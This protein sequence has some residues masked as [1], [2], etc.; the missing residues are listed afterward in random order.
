MSKDLELANRICQELQHR[1]GHAALELMQLYGRCLEAFTRKRVGKINLPEM[2]SDQWV[3]DLLQGFWKKK[4]LE[5]KV[6]CAYQGRKGASLK[7]FLFSVMRNY[8]SQQFKEIIR[9]REI[10]IDDLTENWEPSP[11]SEENEDT[12]IKKIDTAEVPDDDVQE[13]LQR[14]YVDMAL[15]KLSS[16]RPEDANNISLWMKDDLT[17]WQIAQ[18]NLEAQGFNLDED[19]VR[20]KAAALRKQ[21]TRPKTG[22]LARFAVIYMKILDENGFEFEMIENM[23]ILKL[24]SSKYIC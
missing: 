7:T 15:K 14:K 20:K 13:K 9:R 11:P 17:Y 8:I 24:A 18:K 16:K 10:L 19:T 4:I 1:N 6:V 23:P 22:S 21:F 5:E 3:K 12:L 2:D